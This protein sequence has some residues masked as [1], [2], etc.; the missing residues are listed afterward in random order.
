[1]NYANLGDVNGNK[2]EE[3]LLATQTRQKRSILYFGMIPSIWYNKL[4]CD[5]R[6]VSIYMCVGS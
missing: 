3:E 6:V 5:M 4:I 1:M 2:L